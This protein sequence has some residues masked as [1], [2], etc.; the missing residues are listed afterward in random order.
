MAGG[1]KAT[2]SLR[3]QKSLPLGSRRARHYFFTIV[4]TTRWYRLRTW[5]CMQNNFH[6]QPFA[7]SMGV[8]ISLLMIYQK[9]PS[10]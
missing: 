7:N 10:I 5:P 2:R 1:T 9:L 4:V 3:C 6:K 8:D